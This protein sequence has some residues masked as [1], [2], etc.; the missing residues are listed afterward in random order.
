MGCLA[1]LSHFVSHLGEHGLLLYKLLRKT[2]H[3]K[4]TI[5]AQG[6][7]DAL[8]SLLTRASILVPPEDKELLLLYIA[9]TAQVVSSVLIGER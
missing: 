6:L 3:F 4:W 5:E 1:S 9:G 8:K 7:L 2:N